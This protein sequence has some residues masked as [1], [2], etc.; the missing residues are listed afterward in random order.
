MMQN[1]TD[2]Y[3]RLFS[4]SNRWPWAQAEQR[5]ATLQTTHRRDKLNDNCREMCMSPTT[6]CKAQNDG[7]LGT[8][9]ELLIEHVG[10]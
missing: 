8:Q 5:R 2:Q 1:S 9:E 3:K 6:A 10:A 7:K 4:L